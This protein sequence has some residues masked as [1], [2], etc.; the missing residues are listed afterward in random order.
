MH[1]SVVE[2]S[3]NESFG[4]EAAGAEGVGNEDGGDEADA[5]DAGDEIDSTEGGAVVR[6][7]TAVQ[8]S[9]NFLHIFYH[10]HGPENPIWRR[11]RH[12][13]LVLHMLCMIPE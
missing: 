6:V 4:G 10:F 13:K 12:E 1:A 2:F 8:K 3:D 5:G 11:N 7:Q 9:S